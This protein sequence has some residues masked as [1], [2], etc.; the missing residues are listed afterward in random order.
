[1]DCFRDYHPVAYGPRTITRTQQQELVKFNFKVALKLFFSN[2]FSVVYTLTN[3][4]LPF[5]LCLIGSCIKPNGTLVVIVVGFTSSFYTVFNQLAMVLSQVLSRRVIKEFR[6]PLFPAHDLSSRFRGAL[7]N[8]SLIVGTIYG[9]IMMGLFM[10]SAGLYTHFIALYRN[11]QPAGQYA[12]T[13]V[14]SLL[15][16]IFLVYINDILLVEIYLNYGNIRSVIVLLS[17][18]GVRLVLVS[19]FSLNTSVGILGI[20]LGMMISSLFDLFVNL[21]MIGNKANIFKIDKFILKANLKEDLVMSWFYILRFLFGYVAKSIM[22]L[23]TGIATSA[24]SNDAYATMI[25]AR[26][27]WYNILF[28]GGWFADAC[29]LQT[30]LYKLMYWHDRIFPLNYVSL[31]KFNLVT[32]AFVEFFTLLGFGL[33]VPDIAGVYIQ[34]IPV[35]LNGNVLK[36]FDVLTKWSVNSMMNIPL[37]NIG[38]DV[39]SYVQG[40]SYT[41]IYLGLFVWLYS[42]GK[43]GTLTP[44][45]IAHPRKTDIYN[46]YISSPL[47]V[48][49]LITAL[50]LTK[51]IKTGFWSYLQ[52]FT[53]P[54]IFVALIMFIIG[55]TDACQLVKY[56]KSETWL[57]RFNR[58]VTTNPIMYH[59]WHFGEKIR[60]RI[61]RL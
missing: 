15:P 52:G 23:I 34:N 27:I 2:Q 16:T 47:V 30:A 41:M 43:L 56:I 6:N 38:S 3:F 48:I 55:T 44:Y 33:L 4:F 49:T 46:F 32:G 8:V 29:I 21:V 1:M 17:Q 36:S 53:F 39:E 10:L 42:M 37:N 20:G 13:L 31:L 9:T 40:G 5:F 58:Y 12:W 25:I 19:L 57:D 22:V 7:I 60:S 50:M 59:K 24:A 54:L 11:L 26:I 45:S 14:S 61:S 18:Y 28:S 51:G 35:D